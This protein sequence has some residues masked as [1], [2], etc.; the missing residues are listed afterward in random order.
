MAVVLPGT[1]FKEEFR[2]R[3]VAPQMLSRTLDDTS[4][5][6]SPLVPW[7]TC[8]AYMSSTLGVATIAY[9]PF[10]FFNLVNPII[11]FLYDAV[12]FQI[13]YLDDEQVTQLPTEPEQI[14]HYG[15]SGY[16]PTAPGVDTKE[17]VQHG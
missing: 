2:K 1:L 4:V 9:L 15:V 17:T 8:G 13:K 5:I 14:E 12:G 10:C 16:S 11:S 6:T 7:N 3:N